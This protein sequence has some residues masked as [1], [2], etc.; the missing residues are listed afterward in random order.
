M[1][2]LQARRLR[3]SKTALLMFD[4]DVLPRYVYNLFSGET[5]CIPYQPTRQYCR[6]CQETGHRTDVCPKTVTSQCAQWGMGDPPKDHVCKTTCAFCG[7]EHATGAPEP[8]K[9]LKEIQSRDRPKPQHQQHQSRPNQQG[10]IK[11]CWLNLERKRTVTPGRSK[12]RS[13]P[14]SRA[15]IHKRNLSGGTVSVRKVQV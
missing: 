3:G 8:H 11:Q 15:R 1:E 6:T 4:G 5:S 9:K 14:E 13:R 12:S 7:R 10:N 2:V